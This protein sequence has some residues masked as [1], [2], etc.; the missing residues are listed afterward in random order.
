[1]LSLKQKDL[2]N[3]NQLSKFELKNKINKY[4]LTRILSFYYKNCVPHNLGT[5][6]LIEKTFSKAKNSKV[7]INRRCIFN[8]RSR[9]ISR[10]YSVSRILFREMLQFGVVPGSIKAVW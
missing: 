6:N 9:G 2:K 1:M 3:R 5:T 10:K 7:R 8:N 4:L